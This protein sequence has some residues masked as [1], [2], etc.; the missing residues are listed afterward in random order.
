[1]SSKSST[2]A[3]TINP[4]LYSEYAATL[5]QVNTLLAVL[6]DAKACGGERFKHPSYPAWSRAQ[7]RLRE[8]RP[9]GRKP[10]P[11]R[12]ISTPALVRHEFTLDQCRILKATASQI[13][14]N[15]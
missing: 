2:N 9:A 14:A 10:L 6:D 3:K 7:N 13:T 1:M 15:C 8:M 5:E 12:R 11:R 4:A